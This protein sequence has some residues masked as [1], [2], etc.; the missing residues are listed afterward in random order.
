MCGCGVLPV[1]TD[2][3]GTPDCVDKC[4]YDFNKIALGNC[5]CGVS[6]VLVDLNHNGI[7]VCANGQAP[8]LTSEAARLLAGGAAATLAAGMAAAM[9]M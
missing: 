1:D 6:D 8:R 9:W 4:P 7:P 2:M 5:G 3:D